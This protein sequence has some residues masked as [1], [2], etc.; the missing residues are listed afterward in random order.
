MNTKTKLIISVTL[1]TLGVVCRL[2]PHL[3]NFAPVTAVALFAGIYLGRRYAVILPVV[4][5]IIGDLFLGFYEWQMML[6]VYGSFATIGLLGS[7]IKKHKSVETVLAGSIIASVLFFVA[8][9]WA[10]WQFSPWYAK[11]LSG[12]LQ[13]YALALPFFRN[14]LLGDVFYVSALCGAYE[15]VLVWAKKEKLAL[16]LAKFS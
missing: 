16:K 7:L 9:N 1:I 10:V 5:M 8:T 15:A 6:V 12:L 2:L 13:C 3:W 4:T 11:S 14:T